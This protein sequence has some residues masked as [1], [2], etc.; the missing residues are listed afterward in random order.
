VDVPDNSLAP[1][2]TTQHRQGIIERDEN[3]KEGKRSQRTSK[4]ENTQRRKHQGKKRERER[5]RERE[6]R[7]KRKKTVDL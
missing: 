3:Q 5:E 4:A 6:R 1:A 2:P 7:G